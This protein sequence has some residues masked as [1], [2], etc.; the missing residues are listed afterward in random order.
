[1][2]RSSAVLRGIREAHRD[3]GIGARHRD[4]AAHRARADDADAIAPVRRPC[5]SDTPGTF[6]TPRSAKNAWMSALACSDFAQLEEDLA[7]AC[8]PFGERKRRRSFERVDGR[9]GRFEVA[10]RLARQLAAGCE[11]RRGSRSPV[12][13]CPVARA[14]S[15]AH[16][17]R[18]AISR[19]NATAP[20]SEVAFDDA[21]DEPGAQRVGGL[22]R[23]AGHAHLDRLLETDEPRQPLRAFGAGDDAE[24]HLGLSH[25]RVRHGDAVVPGHRHFE[26]AAERGAVHRHDDRLGRCLR[27]SAAGR[28]SR[29]RRSRRPRPVARVL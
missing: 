23:L 1:M 29:A 3:A 12:A 2:P 19:A 26:P 15:D 11:H 7:L 6:D 28:A 18:A 27:S 9:D 25:L 22:D 5:P 13:A 24:V 4:A 10:A 16:R 21:I 14:S 20:G 17:L 8:A